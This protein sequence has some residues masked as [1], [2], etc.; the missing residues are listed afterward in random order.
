MLLVAH[1]GEVIL[2]EFVDEAIAIAKLQNCKSFYNLTK[3][4]CK[5]IC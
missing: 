1:G 2:Q 4:Q 3:R 5:I